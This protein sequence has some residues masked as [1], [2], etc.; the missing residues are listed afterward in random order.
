MT[1]DTE[2]QL[3]EFGLPNTEA[4]VYLALLELGKSQAG[5]I[6][7][8]SGVNR[9]NVYDAL[10]RLIEKGL[11]GYVTENNKRMFEAVNPEK[12]KEILE[13][14]QVKLS[15]IIKD[16]KQRYSAG[17]TEEDAYI[18]R[19]KKGMK[20]VFEDILKEKKELL[21]YGAESRF[22]EMFPFYQKHWN[23]KRARLSIKVKMIYNEK[24]REVKKKEQLKLLEMR[25]L[26]ETYDFPSTIMIYA[27]K[28]VTIVWTETPFAFL[29]KSK[30]AVKSNC[31]FFELLWK[32]AKR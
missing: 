15:S 25:F 9:T 1:E 22:K 29:I 13:E 20:S 19:G 31:N 3:Q 5:A 30:E 32:I 7:K 21:V 18:F 17:K 4:K 26:P 2:K 16:L 10:E 11:V 23:D 14:K 28:V 6:T 27:D 24:V 12:L 8:K